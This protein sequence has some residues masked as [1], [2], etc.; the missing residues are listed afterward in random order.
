VELRLSPDRLCEEV[1]ASQ[2][3]V[4]TREQALEAGLSERQIGWRTQLGRWRILHPGVF[5]V[6]GAPPSWHQ[7]LLAACFW[8]GPLAAASYRAAGILWGLDG[9]FHRLIEI[10]VPRK[11]I[12]EGVIIHRVAVDLPS[13]RIREAIPVTDPTTTLFNLAAVLAPFHMESALESALRLKLTHLDL[14]RSA[15]ADRARSGRN[16]IRLMRRLLDYRDSS[17]APTAS[18]LETLLAQLIQRFGLPEPTRQHVITDE[19]GNFVARPDFAYPQGRIAIEAQSY[20]F[21]H[22]RTNWEKDQDR[23]GAMTA[24]SWVVMYVTDRQ[25]KDHPE[26]VAQRIRA[27]LSARDR[28]SD[29]FMPLR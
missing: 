21:H 5:A 29:R 15:L 28:Q 9:V 26:L 24:L 2:H 6:N 27:A 23:L 14:L 10:S 19:R 20:A 22:G 4:I 16:G 12:C 7:L 25:I 17:T 1:A 13:I 11:L 3:G 18:Q 8:A